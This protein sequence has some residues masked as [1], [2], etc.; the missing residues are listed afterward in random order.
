[1]L[2]KIK[3]ETELTNVANIDSASINA[4]NTPIIAI[5]TDDIL[6]ETKTYLGGYAINIIHGK[7]PEADVLFPKGDSKEDK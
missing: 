5:S 6:T 1:M 4:K 7:V 2:K 3:N